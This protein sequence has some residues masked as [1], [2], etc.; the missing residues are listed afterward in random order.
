MKKVFIV[1]TFTCFLIG[2]AVQS[3]SY[4][5]PLAGKGVIASGGDSCHP[6]W[7]SYRFDIAEGIYGVVDSHPSHDSLNLS[8][9]FFLKPGTTLQ[10]SNPELVIE[11]PELPHPMKA[12]TSEF[13]LIIYGRKEGEKGH[14]ENF[15]V[16]DILKGGHNTGLPEPYAIDNFRSVA[17]LSG[18]RPHFFKLFIPK[19]IANRK[20]IQIEPI[21][22]KLTEETW[23]SGFCA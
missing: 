7:A 3:I 6:P 22:F 4:Y 18:V 12:T 11:S 2:C 14:A 21:D 15:K 13:R 9:S 16:T 10:I 17:K 23:V 20:S 1:F 5:T 19:L 8:L